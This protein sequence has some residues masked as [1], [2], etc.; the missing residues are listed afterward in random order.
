MASCLPRSL[1]EDLIRKIATEETLKDKR[2]ARI[3][4][5]KISDEDV[6]NMIDTQSMNDMDLVE[7]LDSKPIQSKLD[8]NLKYTKE[9]V[10]PF[11][12][13]LNEAGNLRH[14]AIALDVI[15]ESVKGEI[16]KAHGLDI[17][18]ATLSSNGVTPALPLHRMAATIGRRIL[19]LKGYT[20]TNV[21]PNTPASEEIEAL[22]Y[23]AGMKIING[24][25]EQGFFEIHESGQKTIKDY[26]ENINDKRSYD[27]KNVTVTDNPSID[28]NLDAFDLEADSKSTSEQNALKYFTNRQASD[29]TTHNLGDYV[30]VLKAINLVSQPQP[31]SLPATESG[32]GK[33]KQDRKSVV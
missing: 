6:Q 19:Y 25:A 3:D 21:E 10:A 20:V 13:K 4:I 26:L 27:R 22:N 5:W 23:D 9:T 1:V 16:D 32:G 29:I 31:I 2:E 15:L 17:D 8:S 7:N 28:I 30:Q 33:H 18:P 24:L 11:V 14:S 12:K